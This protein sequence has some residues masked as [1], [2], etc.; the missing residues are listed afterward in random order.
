MDRLVRFFHGGSVKENGEFDN[1][2]ED[3]ELFDNPLSF[4]DLVDRVVSKHCCEP[5]EFFFEGQI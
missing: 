3:V 1:M 2:M 4:K 5:C